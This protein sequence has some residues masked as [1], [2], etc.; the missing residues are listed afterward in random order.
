MAYPVSRN[1]SVYDLFDVEADFDIRYQSVRKINEASYI[2]L[3]EDHTRQSMRFDNSQLIEHF[4]TPNSI[5]LVEGYAALV[6]LNDQ[7]RKSILDSLQIAEHVRSMLTVIGWDRLNHMAK[8]EKP[9]LLCGYDKADNAFIVSDECTE[10]CKTIFKEHIPMLKEIEK[11]EVTFPEELQL[12]LKDTKER[13]KI[14]INEFIATTFPDRTAAMVYTLKTLEEERRVLGNNRGK[15][16]LIAGDLHLE[17]EV[18]DPRYSLQSLY[19]L[20]PHLPVVIIRSKILFSER[21]EM[22]KLWDKSRIDLYL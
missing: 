6:E 4:V 14:T 18:P 5:L 22:E 13:L 21:S 16:F 11:D 15:I 20:L 7:Q 2:L 9:T 3:G 19:N 17:N 10:S 12:L 1:P 8:A